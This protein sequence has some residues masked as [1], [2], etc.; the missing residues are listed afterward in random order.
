MRPQ[1][2]RV[3]RK[4]RRAALKGVPTGR[5]TTHRAETQDPVPGSTWRRRHPAEWPPHLRHWIGGQP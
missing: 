3:W 4:A 1:D 5:R 2:T